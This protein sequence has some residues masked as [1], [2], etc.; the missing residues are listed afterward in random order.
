[1]EQ[2]TISDIARISGGAVKLGDLPPLGGE[3]EPV[4]RIVVDSRDVRHGDLFWA[5]PGGEV[6]AEDAFS[7]GALGVVTSGRHVE[8]WAGKFSLLVDD[9]KWSL[10]QLAAALRRRFQGEVIAVAGDDRSS[11]R[12]LI[13][14]SLGPL[15]TP[16]ELPASARGNGQ[17]VA[18]SLAM[19]TL[20]P[21]DSFCSVEVAADLEP[22]LRSTAHMCQPGVVLLTSHCEVTVD[23]LLSQ[24]PA[25]AIAA[26]DNQSLRRRIEQRA[27]DTN[28]VFVGR[29][30]S[31]QLVAENISCRDGKLLF[32]VSG[33]PF[34]V[35]LF[36]RRYLLPA[37]TAIALGQYFGRS[38]REM[39][40]ALA[41]IS[42]PALQ[43]E[44][45]P[46]DYCTVISDCLR[47]GPAAVEE[48][49]QMLR[50][51]PAK[52]RIVVCGKLPPASAA[53]LVTRCG[54]DE[55]IAC[56]EGAGETIA[57]ACEAGMPVAVTHLCHNTDDAYQALMERLQ[58]GD[59]VLVRG[60]AAAGFH[61]LAEAL[62]K[63]AQHP[64]KHA[65]LPAAS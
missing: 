14:Q 5:M 54:A 32:T 42:P 37:L 27:G 22:Q 11:T 19:T 1:M 59:A 45:T 53:S 65:T 63:H 12:M 23:T 34:S 33:V 3:L 4:N 9:T 16:S 55:L 52:R 8:P 64:E 21:D 40:D 60:S 36:G 46:G 49:L 13:Q 41:E 25:V 10:W 6:Y 28:V 29:D 62:K 43:C 26:G 24:K 2:L 44:V 7:R 15:L 30:S 20:Q 51:Y 57:N 39:A 38:I 31:N 35:R 50:E 47:E 18:T 48:A 61:H 58:P 56:G 17:A